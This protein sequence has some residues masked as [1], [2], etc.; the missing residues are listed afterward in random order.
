MDIF[1]KIKLP[2]K[3]AFQ[4]LFFQFVMK[5]LVTQKNRVNTFSSHCIYKSCS[6]NTNHHVNLTHCLRAFR[7]IAR[8]DVVFA[9]ADDGRVVSENVDDGDLPV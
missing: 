8:A 9:P 3:N 5:Y 6:N 1:L 7:H 4:V 2:F